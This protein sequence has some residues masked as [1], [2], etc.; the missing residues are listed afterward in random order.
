MN[1]RKE[2]KEGCKV[3]RTVGRKI[4]WGKWREEG[5]GWEEERK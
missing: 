2:I 5:R 1:G 4:G 3:E